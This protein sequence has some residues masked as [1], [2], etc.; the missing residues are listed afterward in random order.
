MSTVLV[1][2]D[3]QDIRQLIGMKLRR[4]GHRVEV[5][6]DGVEALALARRNRPDLIVLDVMMPG[7]TG[8]EVTRELVLDED[9]CDVPILLLTALASSR[10]IAEGLEAGASAYFQKPFSPSELLDRVEELLRATT[11]DG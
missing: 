9:L 1:A 5:A 3:D 10:D 11:L 8:I 2:D 4:A 6:G 7:K